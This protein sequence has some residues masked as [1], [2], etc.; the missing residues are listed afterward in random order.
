MNMKKIL[1][2]LSFL[3]LGTVAFARVHAYWPYDKLTKEA[4]LIVIATPV[5]VQDTAERTTFPDIMQTD[6]NNVRRPV[7]AIGVETTFAVL[8]VLKGNTSTNTFV[9]HHLRELEN[10]P[11]FNRPGLA[12]FDARDK[13][14]F[15]LF[16]K[17]ESDGRYAPL[18]GQTDP[19]GGV[20]D[21]GT[22]P[23]NSEC[24]VVVHYGKDIT[25]PE[26]IA[27][28][29]QS[30]VCEMMK[31][32]NY[33]SRM[34]HRGVW[35]HPESISEITRRYRDVVANGK[36]VLIVWWHPQKVQS[37]IGE[38]TAVEAIVELEK[39]G[40]WMCVVDD[41]GRLAH[42]GKFRGDILTEMEKLVRELVK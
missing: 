36:Y 4:D 42:L 20:K 30:D 14:R 22:Y 1:P 29:L 6:T 13:K 3:L 31:T 19:D 7:P 17:R 12:T 8:S 23:T 35:Q 25:V 26:A 16:L 32:A 38:V 28:K 11:S 41:E 37:V 2:I 33:N 5:S 9:F 34:P 39:P 40:V 24:S 10:K 18:T 21:L 15:L 27:Q